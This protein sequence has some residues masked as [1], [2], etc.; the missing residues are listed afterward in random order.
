MLNVTVELAGIVPGMAV[1][2][3]CSNATGEAVLFCRLAL[4]V[5]VPATSGF[6]INNARGQP[7]LV[8]AWRRYVIVWLCAAI[9]ANS[10]T[11]KLERKQHASRFMGALRICD[12]HVAGARVHP[13]VRPLNQIRSK[14]H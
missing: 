13:L 12:A 6:A 9:G 11:I 2:Q 10:R 7:L 14:H 5:K 8:S 4:W 1:A 3:K